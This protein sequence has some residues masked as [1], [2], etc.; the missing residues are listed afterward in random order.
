[1]PIFSPRTSHDAAEKRPRFSNMM[2]RM[3][4]PIHHRIMRRYAS[5]CVLLFTCAICSLGCERREA[6]PTLVK[7]HGSV[8]VDGI[9]ASGVV[10]TLHPVNGEPAVAVGISKE[11]GTFE[12]STSEFADG[13]VAGEYQ[14]TCVWST[15]NA[16]SRSQEGDRL[17]GRYASAKTSPVH[18]VVPPSESHDA[19]VIELTSAR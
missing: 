13:A 9:P 11:D 12:I 4:E 8:A 15:F 10:L 14:V 1:M 2:D 6:G 16:V 17:S 18:L 3:P 5:T 19:G 7:I